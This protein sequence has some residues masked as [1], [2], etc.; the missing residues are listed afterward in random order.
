MPGWFRRLKPEL[1]R[2]KRMERLQKTVS[3][4]LGNMC[5]IRE[6][7]RKSFWHNSKKEIPNQSLCVFEG[8]YLDYD[9]VLYLGWRKQQ[10]GG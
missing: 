8:W 9:R 3:K 7:Q 6:K 1:C 4:Y 2:K 10:V 5:I